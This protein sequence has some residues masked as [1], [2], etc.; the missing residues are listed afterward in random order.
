MTSSENNGSNKQAAGNDAQEDANIYEDE[1]N[2]IDYFRVI[3]K[4]RWLILTCSVL[5]ALIVGLSIY[6]SPRSYVVTYTYDVEDGVSSWNLNEKNFNV[7]QSRFYS[8]EN[9][10]K[11]INK[12]QQNKLDEYARQ[13][14][15]FKA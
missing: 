11:I 5:P 13:I 2:L 7:L 14:R 15:D 3:W 8:E 10:N 12:L 9:L 4:H 1:I 6:L